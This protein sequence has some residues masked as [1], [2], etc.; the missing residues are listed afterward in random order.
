M[1]KIS[2][3]L[4]DRDWG[5]VIPA[6]EAALGRERKHRDSIF[7]ADQFTRV[8]ADCRVAT[9]ARIKASMGNQRKAAK[10]PKV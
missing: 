2:I 10:E 7:F 1:V 3:E 4:D 8:S 9:L 5:K 6:V